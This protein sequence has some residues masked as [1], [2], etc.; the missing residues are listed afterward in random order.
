MTD[1]RELTRGSSLLSI[2][3][4]G[5][6]LVSIYFFASGYFTSKVRLEDK[7]T[8]ELKLEVAKNRQI[9]VEGCTEPKFKRAIFVLVDAL[10]YDFCGEGSIEDHHEKCFFQ[11]KLP[12]FSEYERVYPNHAR[13]FKTIADA[14]T[15]TYQRLQ[16]ILSGTI[17]TFVEAG[18]NFFA[19]ESMEDNLLNQIKSAG[20]KVVV[21]GDD[22][23]GSLY[24]SYLS[25]RSMMY[26][27]FDTT[28]IDSL[29]DGIISNISVLK[30]GSESWKL[31]VLHFLGVDHVGHTYGPDHPEMERKLRQMNSLIKTVFEAMDDDTIVFV[32][33]DHGMD[34]LGGHGG[35][36]KE[37][38]STFLFAYSKVHSLFNHNSPELLQDYLPILEIDLEEHGVSESSPSIRRTVS[39][40]DILPTISLLLGIPIP[41]SNLGSVIPEFFLIP[42]GKEEY[43]SKSLASVTRINSYQIKNYIDHYTR[44][45]ISM[46]PDWKTLGDNLASAE[47]L[48]QECIDGSDA[49]TCR[50]S[51]LKFTDYNK[52]I[53][54]SA[55]RYWS[56][57]D[58]KKINIGIMLGSFSVVVCAELL[59]LRNQSWKDPVIWRTVSCFTIFAGVYLVYNLH[60][61]R[62]S[63]MQYIQ[64]RLERA[65]VATFTVIAAVLSGVAQFL[66][67][68]IFTNIRSFSNPKQLRNTL[69]KFASILAFGLYIAFILAL[70]SNSYILSEDYV[71]MYILQTLNLVT[72]AMLA[73]RRDITTTETLSYLVLIVA[74]R[75]KNVSRVCRE[76]LGEDCTTTFYALSTN[77]VS[78]AWLSITRVIFNLFIIGIQNSYFS[79]KKFPL[80]SKKF[81][82]AAGLLEV[83]SSTYHI[84]DS[85]NPVSY[86][87]SELSNTFYLI[88]RAPS[89]LKI[90]I[91][92]FEF[93]ALLILLLTPVIL[94]LVKITPQSPAVPDSFSSTKYYQIFL[95]IW[96]A[97]SLVQK[98][99]GGIVM[100]ITLLQIM[101]MLKMY[102]KL[103]DSPSLKSKN[104][105][106]YVL[107]SP[108]FLDTTI[109]VVYLFFISW[110]TFYTTGHQATLASIHWNSAF[111]GLK[112]L[113]WVISPILVIMNTFGGH[114]LTASAVPLLMLSDPNARN[115]SPKRNIYI[116]TKLFALF[117]LLNVGACFASML[118][119]SANK[120]T[121]FAW[122]IFAPKFIIIGAS[123]LISYISILISLLL[124]LCFT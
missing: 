10:R 50:A 81:L 70:R 42:D 124:A 31:L 88:K 74:E 86:S 27:S 119:T 13:G 112:S 106:N 46:T 58:N 97:I 6:P 37:E 65:D 84:M 41:Y 82:V 92:N 47:R 89:S 59:L 113:N 64:S 38:I 117:W 123:T 26:P 122:K 115:R 18:N 28:D 39:Q 8:C 36:S 66:P 30:E 60:L 3:F 95:V 49:E 77:S 52:N 111:I 15:T 76:E 118:H 14:P 114:I 12:I 11:G 48:Y 100:G 33:G 71:T 53:L 107:A 43:I 32:F 90:I 17:P 55:R 101:G 2:L 45:I 93:S 5:L 40:V 16:G 85:I 75:L 102:N 68:K 98:P 44:R 96:S 69:P 25:E 22:T 51:A 34:N 7:S 103:K 105:K 61:R 9:T 110:N 120:R 79:D 78:P 35:D 23:W 72:I 83:C 108:D 99:M 121:L 94:R 87:G 63:M 62:D 104:M 20:G 29:D 91:A 21:L 109:P 4:M 24:P 1:H 80:L 57:F 67:L 56:I 54:A 73:R 19:P 116:L